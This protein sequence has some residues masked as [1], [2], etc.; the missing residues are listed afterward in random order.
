MKRICAIAFLISILLALAGCGSNKTS[1]SVT[2]YYPRNPKD[3]ARSFS[4]TFYGTEKRNCNNA[5]DLQH[6]LTT[7]LQGPLGDDLISPFPEDTLLTDLEILETQITVCLTGEF[8][9]LSG[10]NLTTACA[11]LSLTVFSLTDAETVRIISPAIDKMPAVEMTMS[12]TNLI[13]TDTVTG[14]PGTG[15]RKDP[16]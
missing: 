14:S 4:E 12:R 16:V 2:F 11:C 3:S 15:N 1:N 9:R 13:L 7:Y 8:S 5:Q 6:L 10:I